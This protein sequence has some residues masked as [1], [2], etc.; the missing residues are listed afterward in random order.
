MPLHPFPFAVRLIG[1]PKPEENLFDACF[2]NGQ[3]QGCRYFRLADENL[4]DPDLYVA[5]ALN[6]KALLAL[7]NQRASDVRPAM[8]VGAP[9]CELPY[10]HIDRP[11]HWQ[12]FLEVMGC[13]VEKR[14]DALSRLEASDI[15]AVPE[16]RRNDRFDLDLTDPAVVEKLRSRVREEG[17]VLVIDRNPALRNYLGD[18]LARQGIAVE[19][20]DNESAA[21][22]LCSRQRFSVVLLNTSTPGVDP[23]RL[24]WGIKNKDDP[25]RIAVVFMVGESFEY[26]RD[27]ATFAGVAGF[28]NKP[29]ASHHLIAVLKKLIKFR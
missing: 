11:I 5:N 26:D 8:L 6:L 21:V 2:G 1:F 24:C 28:V 17:G 7:S 12:R 22:D 29:I 15:V 14:A 19:W 10:P 20:A 9:P 23:Y 4:Q 13:L 27:Q 16:R 18:L 3:E 25:H